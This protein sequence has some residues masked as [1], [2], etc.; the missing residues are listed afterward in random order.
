MPSAPR[1]GAHG[2]QLATMGNVVDRAVR[3][4]IQQLA[5]AVDN[6]QAHGTGSGR[7]GI[8]ELQGQ[9]TAL[10][11]ELTQIRTLLN[12]INQRLTKAGF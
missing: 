11:G 3:F 5:G 1:Q 10:K 2:I 4:N 9:L 7:Q 6:M 8:K 12:S